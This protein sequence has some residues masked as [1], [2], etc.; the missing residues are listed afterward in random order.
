MSIHM[1]VLSPDVYSALERLIADR[2]WAELYDW[3]EPESV[4]WLVWRLKFVDD[5]DLYFPRGKWAT[6]QRIEQLL[7]NFAKQEAEE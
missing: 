3:M 1:R 2:Q 5:T 4:A 6:I 7:N